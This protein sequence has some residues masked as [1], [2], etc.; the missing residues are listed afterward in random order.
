MTDA[1]RALAAP[2]KLIL[3]D[4]P[5][6]HAICG[7]DGTPGTELNEPQIE[8]IHEVALSRGLAGLVGV[9]WGKSLASLLFA[10]VTGSSRPLIVVRSALR[11]NLAREHRKWCLHYHIPRFRVMT[12][13]E[14]S[15]KAKMRELGVYAPDLIV[16][17]EAH[18]LKILTS[19]RWLNFMDYLRSHPDTII[20]FMSGTATTE[21]TDDYAHLFQAALR[22]RS[23]VPYPGELA[24]AAWRRSIGAVPEPEPFDHIHVKPLIDA[25][26]SDGPLY[27]R[28]RE[29]LRQHLNRTAG[30][31]L[32]HEASCRSAIV[33]RAIRNP[34]VPKLVV[35]L[36][37]QVGLDR[38][39]PDGQ[40]I[41]LQESDLIRRQLDYG[42][43]YRKDW[44]GATAAQ[45]DRWRLVV[46]K[47]NRLVTAYLKNPD[48]GVTSPS[49]LEDAVRAGS[50]P[51][52]DQALRDLDEVTGWYKRVPVWVWRGWLDAQLEWLKTRP[53]PSIFWYTSATALDPEFAAE[54]I[55][56]ASRK[57]KIDVDRPQTLACSLWSV[58][59]GFNMQGWRIMRYGQTPRDAGVW[60]QS[61]AR[62]HRLGQMADEIEVE[63]C[64]HTKP[65]RSRL[66]ASMDAARYIQDTTGERQR[67]L[68]ATWE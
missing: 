53:E 68:L 24:A 55:P 41:T 54:G 67:L 30:V 18:R 9:G 22:E 65:L 29:A 37:E 21:T 2:P 48:P 44:G 63:V 59:E 7:W 36:A 47:W 35:D 57:P 61:L 8:M 50:Y 60:Q 42:F 39:D 5:R 4:A 64:L 15:D 49:A 25:Y 14:L 31:V 52:L 17:D 43:W 38:Q 3:P 23:P 58:R 34:E 16:F 6:I 26:P 27:K 20:V 51:E 62:V 46:G 56:F 12:Y 40:P 32:S 45:V 11:E 33:M 66:R 19:A 28:G 13:E 1:Y 10:N